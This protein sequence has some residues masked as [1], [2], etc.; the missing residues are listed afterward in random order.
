MTTAHASAAAV[1]GTHP[2][3]AQ[4]ALTRVAAGNDGAALLPS[5]LGI[6]MLC[7]QGRR[8]FVQTLSD[9]LTALGH[10]APVQWRLCDEWPNAAHAAWLAALFDQ[11]AVR[12]PTL[13]HAQPTADGVAL[14]LRLPLDL[15]HF[16]VHFPSL[17]IL[18]GVVQLAWAQAFAAARLGTPAVCRRVDMLKFQRPLRPGDHVCLTLA[19]QPAQ[20]RLHFTY[21]R[22]GVECSSGRLVWE[23]TGE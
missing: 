17:P 3:V 1:L 6:A 9:H 4:A 16:D 8:A 19:N 12:E 18:P 21:E 5:P 10:A 7:Q 13:L 14:N 22:A 23:T 20:H 2:W 15:A 11:P